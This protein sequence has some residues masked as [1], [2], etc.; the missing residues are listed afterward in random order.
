MGVVGHEKGNF[1]I[2]FLI[3]LKKITKYIDD[4]QNEIV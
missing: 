4:S 3:I 2:S 1:V